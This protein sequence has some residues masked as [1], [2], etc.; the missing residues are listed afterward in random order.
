MLT[1]IIGIGY[2]EKILKNK[3]KWI[4]NTDNSNLEEEIQELQKEL[5]QI[6]AEEKEIDQWINTLQENLTDLAK[7][8][9]NAK[10]A[11]VTHED[12]KSLGALSQDDQSPF[13]VIK[14]P[15]GTTLEVPTSENENLGENKYQ[16]FLKSNSGEI[17]VYVV[18][19][20]T[21]EPAQKWI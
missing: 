4:G 8:E 6:E 21:D 20:G 3:I 14:A 9:A 17:T 7:D 5:A 12:I 19:D 10:Y 2:I 15:K 1:S 18:S 16:L 11:Y 13:L